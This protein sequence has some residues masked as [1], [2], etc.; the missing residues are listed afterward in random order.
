MATAIRAEPVP[1]PVPALLGFIAGF[2][3]ICAYFS[4]FGI[5]VAQ[6]TGSFVLA[7]VRLVSGQHELMTLAAIPCFFVAGGVATALAVACAPS[8]RSLPWVLGLECV[9][10]TA[11][12]ALMIAC[13]PLESVNAPAV[14]AA[15]L[16]GIAAMGVQSAMVRLFMKGAP[17]TNV[18]T[19]N[20]TQLAIDGTILVLSVCGCGDAEQA[21][22]SRARLA[23]YWP[24]MAG[25]I[26]G[27]AAGS[28]CFKL[29][30]LIALGGPVL[31]AY[32][33]LCWILWRGVGPGVVSPLP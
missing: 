33:L 13:S 28:V 5:F 20:T 17:S 23:D 4:L 16:I 22:A 18:M 10:L 29:V 19:T 8:G 7:G 24:P 3:D 30:G 9:L 21:R 25:F 6:L 15:A 31:A 26:L 14:A 2:V 1:R 12:L 32:G 11:M 27:T